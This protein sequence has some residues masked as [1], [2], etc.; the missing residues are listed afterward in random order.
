MKKFVIFL[1]IVILIGLSIFGYIETKKYLVKNDVHTYLLKEKN[2]KE[3]D[4][5]ALDPFVANLDGDKNWLVYVKIKN[6]S[7]KYYYYKNSD[8]D[9]ILLES[10]E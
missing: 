2:I 1:G 10:A 9:R 5:E 7:K 4:I 3:A 6:D 8:T